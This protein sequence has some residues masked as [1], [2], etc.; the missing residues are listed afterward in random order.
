MRGA[1]VRSLIPPCITFPSGKRKRLPGCLSEKTRRTFSEF[2]SDHYI[3]DWNQEKIGTLSSLE[4]AQE[5]GVSD[6]SIIRF[7]RQIGFDGFADLKTH[8]YD[9]LVESA[10]SGLSL[11][12]RASQ[13]REI[14]QNN[15]EPDNFTRLVDENLASVFHDNKQ[16]DFERIADLCTTC[17]RKYIIGLRGYRHH[18]FQQGYEV[19]GLHTERRRKFGAQIFGLIERFIPA[20]SNIPSLLYG[21][22]GAIIVWA[23]LTRT[24]LD[25][26]ADKTAVDNIGG[27]ALEICICSATATLNLNFFAENLAPILIHMVIV[28]A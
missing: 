4:V 18:D 2:C 21:I 27:V 8:I 15:Y 6:A 20:A 7:S 17:R 22:V 14:Y 26:Y 24:G 16:E 5:I 28:I 13:N 10:F 23:I 3:F 12:E 9:M 11:T 19:N 1:V 25:K